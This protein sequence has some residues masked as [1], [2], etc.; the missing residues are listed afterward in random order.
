MLMNDISD[1][2]VHW[3]HLEASKQNLRKHCVMFIL[4]KDNLL[5]SLQSQQHFTD[6]LDVSKVTKYTYLALAEAHFLVAIKAAS[7]I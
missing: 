2:H 5:R 4:V 1:A 3:L 6:N 7:A